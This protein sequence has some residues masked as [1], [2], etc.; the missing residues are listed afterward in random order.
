MGASISAAG[1]AMAQQHLR[2]ILAHFDAPTMGSYDVFDNRQTES[3][4]LLFPSQAIVDTI[5]LLEDATV[6]V[7][8]QTLAVV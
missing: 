5:E 7:D 8:G 1:T 6:L 4:P 3:A 2:A